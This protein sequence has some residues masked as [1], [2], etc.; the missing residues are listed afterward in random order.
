MNF[1]LKIFLA[2][3]LVF[4]LN[5]C[6]GMQDENGWTTDSKKEFI[7]ILKKD[8]YAS[9]C[10]SQSLATDAINSENSRLMKEMLIVYVQNLANSCIDL[11]A[12]QTFEK[13][14]KTQNISTKLVPY[15]QNVNPA[16]IVFQLKAKLPIVKILEPYI[17]KISQFSKLTAFYSMHKNNPIVTNEIRN[18]LRMSIERIK[19]M[20]QEIG[21]NY[22]LINIPEFKFRLIEN[23]QTALSFGIVTGK[24]TMQTPIFSSS[25]KYIV[26]NPPWNIPDSIARKSII[27]KMLRNPYSLKRRG[28][29]IRKTYDLNSKKINRRS[30]NWK[31]YVGG[32][33]YVPYKFI[34]VAS[35][36]NGLGRVKFIFPNHFAVYMH[37]TQSKS[38]FKRKSRA[39]SHGCVRLSKP[40]ELLNYLV[41]NYTNKP[42]EA[43]QEE[44]DSLKTHYVKIIKPLNVHTAYLTTYM[45]ENNTLRIFN[46]VYGLDKTQ[47]LNF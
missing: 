13:A 5:G 37:D 8:T 28:I 3:L 19:L 1:I 34:Q 11:E 45:D 10:N 47:K 22:V 29:V 18:A 46:D 35:R 27:P 39:F 17:P 23:N 20:K 38:L 41:L 30:I 36:K 33:G 15:L 44:Y 42:I 9:I 25:L 40:T 16:D 24:T 26:M 7:T 12:L 4:L 31:P 14:Q 21:E 6:L 32:K 2:T 43:M